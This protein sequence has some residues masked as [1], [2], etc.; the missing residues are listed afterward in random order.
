MKNSFWHRQRLIN[1]AIYSAI[2]DQVLGKK[3]GGDKN[4]KEPSLN[5]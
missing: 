3:Y 4:V 2:T 5:D 1:W